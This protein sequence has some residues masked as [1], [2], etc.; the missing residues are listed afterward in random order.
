MLIFYF[1][2]KLLKNIWRTYKRINELQTNVWR[3]KKQEGEHLLSKLLSL[4]GEQFIV[5]VSLSISNPASVPS[6]F[7]FWYWRSSTRL[8]WLFSHMLWIDESII[9][10]FQLAGYRDENTRK[11]WN[12]YFFGH[13][14]S[15]LIP[16][17]VL[18][19][20]PSV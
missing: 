18:Y 14:I 9:L 3:G 4:P 20:F 10:F 11:Y 7:P 17:W 13:Q 6:R 12:I 2:F 19:H 8:L 15:I 16:T 1:L 5:G